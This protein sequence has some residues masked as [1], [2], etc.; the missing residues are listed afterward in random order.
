MDIF[1]S[2]IYFDSVT[3]KLDGDK[4]IKSAKTIADLKNLFEDEVARSQMVQT[5]IAY[6]VEFYPSDEAGTNGGLFFGTS[7]L[8]PGKVGN[9]YFM[10]KGHFHAERDTAEFYWCIKGEGVLLLM[11]ETRN[12]KAEYLKPGSLHYINRRIAH[13]VCNIGEETLVFGA[14]W[15]ANAGHDYE[16]IINEGFPVR[17]ICINGKPELVDKCNPTIQQSNNPTIQQSNNPTIPMNITVDHSSHIPLH[18][19]LEEKLRKLCELSEYKKGALFPQEVALAK[20]LG[21]SRNTVRAAIDKLVY[22]GLLVRKR[23]VGTRV[24]EKKLKTTKLGAWTSFTKEMK[25]QGIE[26]QTFDVLAKI[27]PANDEI[28]NGL[29]IKKSN[30]VLKLSR[31]RGYND[32][33]IVI[34][35]SWF[36]PRINV[37]PDEDFSKPLYSILEEKYDTIP[38]RSNEKITAVLASKKIAKILKIKPNSPLLKRQRIVTDPGDRVFEYAVIYYR[39]DRF[40]YSIEIEKG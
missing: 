6:R 20:R 13:R 14:C 33:R 37:K 2:K 18:V 1:D 4:I 3:G 27:E 10:T 32:E 22:D 21:V 12:C 23:G 7:Y 40:T 26:V 11:D 9:E 5:Q 31:V 25:E 24:I 15:P 34:F 28:A 30:N 38:F 39:G 17:L 19:Q 36:H 35:N 29:G 8:E 16:N